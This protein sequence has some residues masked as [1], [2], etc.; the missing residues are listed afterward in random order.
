MVATKARIAL[1]QYIK[2]KPT[3]W[4]IKLFVLSDNTGYTVDF[5]IYTEKSGKA[6]GKELSF[7][8][9]MSLVSKNFLGSGYQIY[10]DNFY[11]SPTLFHHLHS[12][13]FGA[14]GTFQDTRIGV[15]KSK[16]IALTK[17]CPGGTIRWIRDGPLLFIKWM[18]TREVSVCSTM[19]TAFSGD[20][21][22]RACKVGGK[23]ARVEV[24]APS[25]LNDYNSFMGGVDLSDQLIGSYSSGRK[26]RKWYVTVLHH[27]I[28]IAVTNSY[29]LHKDLCGRLEQQPMTHQAFMEQ[30]TDEL[31]GAT[32]SPGELSSRGY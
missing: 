20:T 15:P 12:L 18:E 1:K 16:V 7:D 2:N 4:G 10:C 22:K 5:H 28:D 9:V 17:N 32:S 13:G 25:A 30:L 3:R 26:S 11:T 29:L 8:A 6:T 21:V 24:Q 31:C 19:H 27:F 14:C 23:Y